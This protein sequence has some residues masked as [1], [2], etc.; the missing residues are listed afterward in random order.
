MRI[1]DVL[2]IAMLTM[3]L[4]VAE[5]EMADEATAA[6]E[7]AAEEQQEETGAERKAREDAAVTAL[8]EE[9][10]EQAE[11]DLDKVVCKNERVVGSRSKKRVC[12]TVRDVEQEKAATERTLRDR[13]RSG[14][15][16][17]AADALG[18]N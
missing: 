4:A 1:M 18:S 8:V 14:T 10:N 5:D 12:R 11:S 13:N 6:A 15:V 16:P 3:S 2:L 9:Y 7:A 17:A